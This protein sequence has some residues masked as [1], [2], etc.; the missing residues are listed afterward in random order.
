MFSRHLEGSKGLS[1]PLILRKPAGPP[2][3][4][5]GIRGVP[6]ERRTSPG[7]PEEACRAVSKGGVRR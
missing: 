1:I 2:E 3:E 4:P 6:K 5:R 7:H